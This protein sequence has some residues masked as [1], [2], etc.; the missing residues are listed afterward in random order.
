[1]TYDQLLGLD[2]IIKAGSFKAA[3]ER[4]HK[5]QP[6]ISVAIKKLEE[7]FQIKIFSREEYR[8][9][10]T[11]DGK[12]F[13]EKAKLA[14]FHM[15]SLSTLGEELALGIEREIRIGVDV[16]CPG[17]FI[18][19]KLRDFFKNYPKTNLHL[20]MDVISGTCEK[21]I[22]GEIQIGFFPL[23]SDIEYIDVLDYISISEVEMIPVISSTH[24]NC[25]LNKAQELKKIPQIII[26]SSGSD[27]SQNFGILE[28]GLQWT[29]TDLWTKFEIIKGGLGWGRLPYHMIEKELKNGELKVLKIPGVEGSKSQVFMVKNRKKALGPIAKELWS[30]F[31]SKER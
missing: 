24:N 23:K 15:H 12:A 7:E 16:I 8:P 6:S 20:S 31:K 5:S 13:Y 4:L 10:L 28:D 1:M 21:L 22:N 25:K 19:C 11:E 30:L 3:S 18:Y 29:V 26:E 17:P 14:L 27:R 9:K 2:A